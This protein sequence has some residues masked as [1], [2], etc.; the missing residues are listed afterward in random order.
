MTVG[1]NNSESRLDATFEEFI[2]W[3]SLLR[4][5]SITETP[6]E[7]N[8]NAPKRK[9][10]LQTAEEERVPKKARISTDHP[11]HVV[12]F[13]QN[14][15]HAEVLGTLSIDYER[16]MVGDDPYG[17]CTCLLQPQM[18]TGYSQTCTLHS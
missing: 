7:Q 15:Q 4:S 9:I 5:V 12:A 10:A 8:D 2:N 3:N 1:Q 13:G 16:Q 6:T 17:P 14:V 11:S 18:L